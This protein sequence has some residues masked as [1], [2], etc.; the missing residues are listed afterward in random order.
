MIAYF[1][2]F[3]GDSNVL[4][5]SKDGFGYLERRCWAMALL[6]AAFLLLAS[7]GCSPTTKI[8]KTATEVSEI[9]TSSK[10]R[11]A[12]IRTEATSPSPNLSLIAEEASEGEVEQVRIIGL[13]ADIHRTLPSVEDQVPEWVYTI[14]YVA[15]ALIALVGAWVLWHTGLGTLVKRIIGFVPKAKN[16]R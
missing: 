8:A 13:T 16:V 3:F 9:A 2:I 15:I 1:G 4:S 7:Q 10:D 14:Q 6:L 5:R 12:V 11:F